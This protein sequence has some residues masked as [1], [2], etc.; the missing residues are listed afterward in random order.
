MKEKKE[1]VIRLVLLVITASWNCFT[2][3]GSIVPA[4]INLS[5]PTIAAPSQP[6]AIAPPTTPTPPT[7][8]A[9]PTASGQGNNDA[10]KKVDVSSLLDGSKKGDMHAAYLL[11]NYIGSTISSTN[12]ITDPNATGAGLNEDEI[13]KTFG[14]SGL[15]SPDNTN[16]DSDKHLPPETILQYIKQFYSYIQTLAKSENTQ[17]TNITADDI[18]KSNFWQNWSKNLIAQSF[19]TEETISGQIHSVEQ[20][21][22]N[23]IPNYEVSYY[24]QE[25]TKKRNLSE[26]LRI[27]LILIN[28]FRNRLINNYNISFNKAGTKETNP[29]KVYSQS[30]SF[31]Q[32]SQYY[33]IV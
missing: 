7:Q 3:A 2:I 11:F 4:G 29:A 32:S 23:N 18:I 17:K 25:F 24:T 33:K 19:K 8:I 31:V 30:Q 1:L 6:G 9:P 12:I 14:P 22:F 20:F 13:E 21:M 26:Y 10:N 27:Q 16:I 15:L 5:A 28:S